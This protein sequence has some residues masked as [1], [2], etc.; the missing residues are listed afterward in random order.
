MGRERATAFH[1]HSVIYNITDTASPK[2]ALRASGE[3]KK[4][5]KRNHVEQINSKHV[6]LLD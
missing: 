3:G 4:K 5:E 6:P 2:F 1:P